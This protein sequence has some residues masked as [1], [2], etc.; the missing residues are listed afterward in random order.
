EGEYTFQEL[1]KS[2]DEGK[3]IS[4]IDGLVFKDEN[5]TIHARPPNGYIQDLDKI[6]YPSWE[7]F[8]ASRNYFNHYRHNPL[9]PIMATRGCP[10]GCIHC[11]K[12]IHGYKIRKRSPGNI[13]GELEYLRDKFGAREVIFVD[14]NLTFDLDFANELL[15]LII[16]REVGIYL[17]M[18][19]GIRA[20]TLSPPL[21][22][23]MRRAGV[24]G[25]AIGVESGVQSIVNKIG[26]KLDLDKV[27]NTARLAKE[28]GFL[29]RAFF[30]LG[31]P[32]DSF[33]T[34]RQT[35]RFAKEID[36]DFA[37][38]FIT[39]LFPGTEMYDIVHDIGTIGC[40][41]DNDEA[42]AD[43]NKQGSE[44][45]LGFFYKP[46]INFTFGKLQPGDVKRAYSIAVREFYMRPRK[47]MSI[48][49][50]FHTIPEI[51]WVVHYFLVS[52]FNIIGNLFSR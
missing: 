42:R 3:E 15:D 13:V 9:Y 50:T 47:I 34:M 7:H 51:K 46:V 40:A 1:V 30:Q 4:S 5:G 17:L 2:L 10:Y 31:L 11:T 32:Y 49:S 22:K 20:D 12:I 28:Y 41:D 33:E 16:E 23:K 37:L 36:P 19:N 48:I 29:L 26:K 45:N 35:I 21:L 27:R 52:I 39:T 43:P 24:Y 18:P 44:V 14:D 38:F 6:P 8:P 25:F